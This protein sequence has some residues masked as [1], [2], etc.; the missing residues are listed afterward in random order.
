MS[1][2]RSMI[3]LLIR[4]SVII[5]LVALV[6]G[7]FIFPNKSAFVIGLMIG[8]AVSILKIFLM[9]N[10]FRRAVVKEAHAATSFVRAHYFLRYTI[11]FV[12]LFIGV[13]APAIDLVGLIIGLFVLKP[14]A[15]IQ[16]ILEPPVPKD[17][18]VEFLEWEEEDEDE[19][20]DFW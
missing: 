1:E 4:N 5:I 6:L 14:A 2:Q 8:G 17:G 16:G 10:T 11:T 13:I 19:K 18:T 3:Y 15:Y 12:V 7:L 9:E 20:S